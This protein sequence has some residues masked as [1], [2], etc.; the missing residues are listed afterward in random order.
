V[1]EAG[2]VEAGPPAA[3]E[4]RAPGRGSLARRLIWLALGWSAAVLIAAGVALSLFFHQAALSRFDQSLADTADGLYAGATV[5]DGQVIAPPLTD[6]RALRAYSG[7]YWQIA[8]PGADGKLHYLARSRSLWD[9]SLAAPADAVERLS[10]MPGEPIHYDVRGP[11]DEPLRAL[12]MMTQLP[13][14]S[15]PVVFMAAED[16]RPIDRDVRRFALVTVGTLV[17]LALGLAAAIVLQVRVGLGPLFAMGREIAT[18]R[19]GKAQRLSR[20]YPAEL[21][22][23]AAELNA[24][25]DH[26][27]EVVERQRTHVGNLAHALKTPLSVMLAESEREPGPLSEVVSRQAQAMRDHVEHHLR[28]ARA[29]ARRP[30]LGERTPVAEVLDELSRTLDRIFT[31]KLRIDWDAPDELEF[32]GERQDLLEMAGN[33]L[34][35]ACKWSRSRVRATAEEGPDPRRFRLTVEDDGPGLPPEMRA[36]VIKRGERLDENAPGSGLGLSIV[37]ELARAYGGGLTLSESSLGGLKIVLD[38]PRAEI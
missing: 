10:R 29:A 38:L 19:R 36:A 34:E 3:A 23:L 17:L 8:E 25:L 18:V 20:A 9:S 13:G 6:A 4:A 35:N 24:L 22:P 16:R 27:Q 7:K 30:G 32:A 1:A 14:R 5:E 21:A 15:T 12:A 11:A 31:G 28:R 37:D 33:V 26:N 2:V